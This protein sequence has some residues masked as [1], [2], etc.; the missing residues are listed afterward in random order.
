MAYLITILNIET[1]N[2]SWNFRVVPM[3]ELIQLECQ[4]GPYVGVKTAEF[5][6]GP[7]VGVKTAEFQGGPYVGVKTAE[8]QGGPYVGVKTA[9][10]QGGPYVGVH[11]RRGDFARSRSDRIP[12]IQEVAS[13]VREQLDNLAL[14][15]VYM[16]T[17]G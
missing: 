12:T 14:N 10:F 16:S 2:N 4:G 6:G 8:F 7:Y 17:D 1:M 13:A 5:Q 3:L 11:M 9:E 15:S